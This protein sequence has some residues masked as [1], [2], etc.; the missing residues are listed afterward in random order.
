[1]SIAFTIEYSHSLMII[2]NQ[3]FKENIKIKFVVNYGINTKSST[4]FSGN[5]LHEDECSVP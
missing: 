4:L 2:S 1:M 3:T 5:K